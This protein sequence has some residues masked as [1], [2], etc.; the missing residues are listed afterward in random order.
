MSQG[1]V[2][3]PVPEMGTRH[4]VIA[5]AL[6]ERLQHEP[7]SEARVKSLISYLLMEVR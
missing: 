7:G 4:C 6:W 2:C 3:N 1:Y 5:L